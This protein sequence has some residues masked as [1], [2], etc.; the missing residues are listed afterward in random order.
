MFIYL[1][2]AT[3]QTHPQAQMYLPSGHHR[4]HTGSESHNVTHFCWG[5]APCSALFHPPAPSRVLTAISAEMLRGSTPSLCSPSGVFE[6][7]LD[8][9]G[10]FQAHNSLQMT[11]CLGLES[12]SLASKVKVLLLIDTSPVYS[13]PKAMENFTSLRVP[14]SWWWQG[15]AEVFT[16]ATWA[17]LHGIAAD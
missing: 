13:Q 2:L 5:T 14:E 6:P 15:L 7:V 8:T 11:S 10:P 12:T 3:L 17:K 16:S 9:A 1:G 4:H